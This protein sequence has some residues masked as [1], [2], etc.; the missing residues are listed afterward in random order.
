MAVHIATEAPST[1]SRPD[2]DT[3]MDGREGFSTHL[4]QR[5]PSSVWAYSSILIVVS[6]TCDGRLQLNASAV[7]LASPFNRLLIVI[8][9]VGS[10]A[11]PTTATVFVS[12]NVLV[13]LSISCAV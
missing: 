1:L 9:T 10:P 4:I 12:T 13:A 11:V 5:T 6:R 3:P 7:L 2:L 8:F